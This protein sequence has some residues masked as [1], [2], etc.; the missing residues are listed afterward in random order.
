MRYDIQYFARLFVQTAK[1]TASRRSYKHGVSV[2]E[3]HI[4]YDTGATQNSV[5]TFVSRAGNQS[6]IVRFNGAEVPYAVYLQYAMNVGRTNKP[7]M[8]NGFLQKFAKDDF[9]NALRRRQFEVK[10]R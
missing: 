2:G 9:V 6:A 10:I 3:G 1:S 8:H 4:P 7:N 5:F